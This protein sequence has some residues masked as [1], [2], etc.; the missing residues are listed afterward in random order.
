MITDAMLIAKNI[1]A[2][3]LSRY[4][5]G[6]LQPNDDGDLLPEMFFPFHPSEVAGVHYHKTGSGDG[7]Y[8]RL[9]D[10]RVFSSYGDWCEDT[11]PKNYD[12]IE[13]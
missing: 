7:V 1:N 4:E 2:V 5:D 12:Q 9:K 10:G 13:N 11:D 6:D 8:F 3:L